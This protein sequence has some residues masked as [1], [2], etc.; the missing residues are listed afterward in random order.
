MKRSVYISPF[1]IAALM[2]IQGSE[3]WAFNRSERKKTEEAEMR[4]SRRPS[5]YAFVAPVRNTTVSNALQT[6]TNKQTN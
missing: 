3:N 5:G 6:Y 2:I 4:F 1:K